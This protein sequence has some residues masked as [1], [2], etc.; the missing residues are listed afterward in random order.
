MYKYFIR[1]YHISIVFLLVGL[2]NIQTGYAQPNVKF[3]HFTTLEGLSQNT[4]ISV[5][6]DRDGFM[7]FGTQDGLNK[8]DGY[9]FKIYRNVVGDKT[10]VGANSINVLYQDKAGNMWVGTTAGLSLYNRASDSFITYHSNPGDNSTLTSE[11]IQ[12]I[13]E[14]DNGYLWVG[15]YSGLNLFD[16][17]TRKVTRRFLADNKPGSLINVQ[18]SIVTKDRNHRLWVGTTKGLNLYNYKT[19]KFAVYLHDDKDARTIAS[20]II[21]AIVDDAKGN[22]WIGTNESGVDKLNIQTGF[23]QHYKHKPQ[24][25]HSLSNNTIF[26]MTNAGNGNLWIG[27][28]QG[29]DFYNIAKNTFTTYSNKPDD[30]TTL[31]IAS[32][33]TIYVDNLGILWVSTYSGGISKFDKN[34]ALF[35]VYHY[36]SDNK[37][38]L[39]YKVITSFAEA[40]NGDIWVGTDGGGLDL[41]DKKTQSFTHYMHKEGVKNTLAGNSVLVLL[42]RKSQN[43]LWI[44]TYT[45]GVDLYDPK[46]KTFTNYTKGKGEHPISDERIYALLE[47]TRNNLWIG[48]NGGG[49]DV[50]NLST[51]KVKSLKTKIGDLNTIGNNVIRCFYEDKK[52]DIWIGTYDAGIS[53]YHWKTNTITRL[54]KAN[55]GLSNDIIYTIYADKSNNIWIGTFGGGLNKYDYQHHKFI[56][57]TTKDGLA[58]NSVNSIIQDD[59]GYLWLSTNNGLSRF[60]PKNSTFKNYTLQN[61]LQNHEFAL[62][63]G[64]K[65]STGEIYFGGITGFNSFDPNTINENKN[66]PPIVFTDFQLFNKTVIAGSA[67]SPLQQSITDTRTI[68]LNYKQTVFTFEFSAL[69]YTIPEK[70]EYA[71]MLEGFEKEWNYVGN[72]HKAT[73]TNL[74]PGEYTFRVKASNNDGVWN[75]QGTSMKI[76]VTPPFWLTWWFKLFVGVFA[77][78]IIYGIYQYRVKNIQAQKR[79]LE[80][81]VDERTREVLQQAKDLQSLNEELQATSEELQSQS[82][83]LQSLNGE[84]IDQTEELQTLNEELFEQRLQEQR[85]RAD[86]E[87]ARLEAE[88]ANQAKSI[89]LATMSHEIR[90]PMN[91]VIGMASLLGETELNDEQYDYAKT[92]IHSGEALLNIINGILDFSKIES[93]KMELDPN[94]FEL[95]SC[96]EEVLDLFAAKASETN[97]DLIYQI[98]HHVPNILIADSMRLRQ[99]LTNLVGNAMK[100]THKGEVFLNVTIAAEMD[101]ALEL[102]FEVSD[103]GI[104]IPAEKLSNLFKP[105]TQVDSSTTRRYGGT[106]LGL[107]ISERLVRLMGGDVKVESEEGKGTKFSFTIKCEAL[108][109]D[110]LQATTL[111][112]VEG[113]RILIVDD[114]ET[115]LKV[116][117]GQLDLWKLHATAAHSG[118]EALMLL[119]NGETFDMI[120]TDMQMPD[121]DGLEFARLVKKSYPKLPVILLSSIGDETRKNYPLLFAATLTKPVKQHHLSMVIQNE[122]KHQQYTASN[123]PKST[124]F[125]S[126]DFAEQHPVKLLVAEDNLINQKLI[127]KILNKLGYEPSLANNGTEAL[128]L[129]ADETYDIILMDIQMPEMD[130]L[131]TT[132]HIREDSNIDQP[133][134]VAMTAN[135]MPEDR[136]DCYNAGMDNYISKPL[137]LDLLIGILKE[138]YNA[139]LKA[140]K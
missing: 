16:T 110:R 109:R 126:A 15:T 138:G 100:F 11:A 46:T 24:D 130:G 9:H 86:A 136:E 82:V 13:K 74:D 29:L 90:T 121:M 33:R 1:L 21:T 101:T 117:K 71:Y 122:F 81:Q 45:G 77:C 118:A 52:G 59:K 8:Y 108:H 94:E 102:A 30:N 87:Q 44:G 97:V 22:L 75:Q 113:K 124:S 88:N 92:I 78:L 43:Q 68:K 48:S 12:A 96:I 51:K 83:E 132:R 36:Q 131:E 105:F 119:Q 135:A 70:N 37:H 6:R 73:Y 5:L 31:S 27:T 4:V 47:D 134:I 2:L 120:I 50:F 106:G 93:G 65:A 20:N 116:L 80:K 128:K 58:N 95:R 7:W 127:I 72:Q 114:N 34:L 19:G 103:T 55:S 10:S 63:A 49:V 40:S 56:A 123:E 35:N 61:G 76:I 28:E 85:A 79:V 84:L 60:N 99:I 41:L 107:A 66:I 89:F 111:P 32:V 18:I 104:G 139:K 91:G 57:Y 67:N 17:K 23:F 54:T 14:D 137:K 112:D 42:K 62:H 3:T 39:S 64:F 133:Y 129:M 115:N 125:L 98:D 26:S 53:I 25:A 69:D 140:I 38:G